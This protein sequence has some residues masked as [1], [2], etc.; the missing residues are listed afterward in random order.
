MVEEISWSISQFPTFLRD[1]RI[2][3]DAYSPALLSQKSWARVSARDRELIQLPT[4]REHQRFQL[5]GIV[6]AL[7]V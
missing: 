4:R 6:N 2:R 1:E 5:F 3:F 7:S